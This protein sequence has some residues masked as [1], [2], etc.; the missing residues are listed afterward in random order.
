MGAGALVQTDVPGQFTVSLQAFNGA[1]SLGTFT[2]QSDAAGDAVYLGV[3]DNTGANVTSIVYSLTACAGSCSDFAVD[4]VDL[5][6][7][8]AS[9]NFSLAASPNTVTVTQG[10]SGTSTIT[11]TPSNGFTRG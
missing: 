11:I 2:Q 4:A 1:T 3:K 9:Q 5:A 7:S 8:Q 10:N 6:T